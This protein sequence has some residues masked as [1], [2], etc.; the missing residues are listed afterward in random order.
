ME[1]FK[2]LRHQSVKIYALILLL[3]L[4]NSI[5]T[6]SLL[7]LINNK[8]NGIKLPFFAQY[9]WVIY[10]GLILASYAVTKYFQSYLIRLSHDFGT[11]LSIEIFNKLRL[12][13]YQDYLKLGENKIRTAMEDVNRIQRFPLIFIDAFNSLIIIIIS[14]AYLFW[15]NYIIAFIIITLLISLAVYYYYQNIQIIGN[16]NIARDLENV[17]HKNV[18]D[19]LAG[20]KEIKMSSVRSNNIFEKHIVQNRQKSRILTVNSLI[21]YL[22]NELFGTYSF[23]FLIGI[24][25][26]LIPSLLKVDFRMMSSFVITI[27]YLI[28]PIGVVIGKLREFAFLNI[29]AERL[30]DFNETLFLQNAIQGSVKDEF[31]RNVFRKI[32]FENVSF[33]Y[34][35]SGQR[36]FKLQPISLEIKRGECIFITGGNGSGKSTFINILSGL[37]VPTSGE[38]TYNDD[39]VNMKN[40]AFYRDRI[41]AIFTDCHLFE[42]NYNEFDLSGTNKVL[43]NLLNFMSLDQVIQRDSSNNIK[44]S[45]SKGQQKRLALIYAILENKD[46]IILDEWAAEQDPGFRKF[47]YLEILPYLIKLGKTVIAVTHDDQYFEYANRVIEF[48]NGEIMRDEKLICQ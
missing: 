18:N 36:N 40:S 16:L 17:F 4:V 22:N 41:T 26:F 46:V 27:L 39:M 5:W 25:V 28:G 45:L 47:F 2:L 30:R 31:D 6:S 24:V 23:Y 32:T 37:Y 14:M 44:V 43:N 9:D 35:S 33:E 19:F 34:S 10:L 3:G 48:S 11:T 13:N 8:I 1:L 38:I 15:I 42:E 29:S 20:F 12:T 21:R 7:L